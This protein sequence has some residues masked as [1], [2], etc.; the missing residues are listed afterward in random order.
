L[1]FQAEKILCILFYYWANIPSVSGGVNLSISLSVVQ[2]VTCYFSSYFVKMD[3][4]EDHFVRD[5]DTICF[6]STKHAHTL[7]RTLSCVHST[8]CYMLLL[9][10][11]C[12]DGHGRRSLC[13]GQRHNMF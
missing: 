5:R 13:K 10:L 2:L 12:E 8:A 3:M 1:Y 6:S 4:E 7:Y 11:F 9:K